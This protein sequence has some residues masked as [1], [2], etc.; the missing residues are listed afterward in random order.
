MGTHTTADRGLLNCQH[1][2]QDFRVCNASVQ[3]LSTPQ[4][5]SSSLPSLWPRTHPRCHT[6]RRPHDTSISLLKTSIGQPLNRHTHSNSMQAS[7]LRSTAA[8]S[9]CYRHQ[10]HSHRRCQQSWALLPTSA[11]PSGCW[12][13]YHHHHHHAS[14]ATRA[15]PTSSSNTGAAPP[16]DATTTT[17]HDQ[18]HTTYI[19]PSEAHLQHLAAALAAVRQP[20]DVYCLYGAVGAGKSTFR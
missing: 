9:L 8:R 13:C 19:A 2:T 1:T 16:P 12:C 15:A 5:H 11:S 20:G 3:T 14:V 17:Q 10:R 4:N 7:C 6:P 18:S